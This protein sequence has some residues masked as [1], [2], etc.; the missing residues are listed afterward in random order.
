MIRKQGNIRGTLTPTPTAPGVPLDSSLA[1][2]TLS[3]KH[4]QDRY[5]KI[6]K[7]LLSNKQFWGQ[8]G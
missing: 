8:A 7:A 6:N 2:I 3:P 4:L 1:F 5:H